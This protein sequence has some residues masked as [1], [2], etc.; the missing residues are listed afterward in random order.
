MIR[1]QTYNILTSHPKDEN[2]ESIYEKDIGAK[3]WMHRKL[4]VVSEIVK[5]DIIVLVEATQ[6]QI[7]S[8][9]SLSKSLYNRSYSY[10]LML[11]RNEF[12]GTAILFD[13]TKFIDFIKIIHLVSSPWLKKNLNFDTLICSK[14]ADFF[15]I[16]H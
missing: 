7:D 11:K 2:I 6:L 5:A 10:N 3:S 1:F 12:D 8:I 16:I 9:I 14:F 13:N 4:L 15:K